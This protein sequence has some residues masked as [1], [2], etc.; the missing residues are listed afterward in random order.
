MKDVT[1]LIIT[2]VSTDWD[3]P[4]FTK[5]SYATSISEYTK[6]NSTILSMAINYNPQVYLLNIIVRD[7][8]L[9]SLYRCCFRFLFGVVLDQLR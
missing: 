6:L 8:L 3:K 1:T 9:N 5:R 4:E 7:Q 2:I